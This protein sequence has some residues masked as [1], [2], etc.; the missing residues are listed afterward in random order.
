VVDRIGHRCETVY[1][2]QL[3]V[4]MFVAEPVAYGGTRFNRVELDTLCG[5]FVSHAG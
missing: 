2:A 5:E 1:A 4:H 3:A